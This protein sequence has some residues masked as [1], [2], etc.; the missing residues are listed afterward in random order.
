MLAR[1]HVKQRFQNGKTAIGKKRR[2]NKGIQACIRW[3]PGNAC[4]ERDQENWH[5]VFLQNRAGQQ[6]LQSGRRAA[7]FPPEVIPL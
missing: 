5:L 6:R 7:V 3:L 2:E 1:R 4:L